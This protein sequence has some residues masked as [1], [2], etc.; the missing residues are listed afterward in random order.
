MNSR[1]PLYDFMTLV[2]LFICC[3]HE[4]FGETKLFN[5]IYKL[6]E[7]KN[8]YDLQEKNPTFNYQDNY[9]LINK[10]KSRTTEVIL[11]AAYI[12]CLFLCEGL[13]N[14]DAQIL[15]AKDLLYRLLKQKS[16][17]NDK[18]F[19]KHFLMRHQDSTMRILI[20]N[21][22]TNKQKKAPDDEVQEN[23]AADDGGKA[24]VERLQ[25]RVKE[26]EEKLAAEKSKA[27]ELQQRLDDV[28][29][30]SQEVEKW[31]QEAEREKK[32]REVMIVEL[33]LPIFYNIE[34][35][36]QD[37]LEKVEGMDDLQITALVREWVK[38]KKIS[39]QSKK[40]KLWS[41]LHAARLYRSTE[42][43]WNNQV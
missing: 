26:L 5:I 11:W 20:E 17:L 43:N 4:E 30:N 24:E 8:L 3:A 1:L 29:G 41:V 36:V 12:Y 14:P 16:C 21:A 25:E 31:K 37:F 32:A 39:D 35:D 2:V 9:I 38:L 28:D 18:A 13:T 15:S 40:R 19:Q 6:E 7:G 33:L 34:K 27:T 23:K 10:M 22:F 42:T